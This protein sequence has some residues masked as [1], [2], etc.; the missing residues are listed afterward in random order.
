MSICTGIRVPL[1]Q[2]APDN[3]SGSTRTTSLMHATISAIMDPNVAAG[4]PS[5]AKLWNQ[6]RSGAHPRA[7]A[8][9]NRPGTDRGFIDGRLTS[10]RLFNYWHKLRFDDAL[11]RSHQAQPVDTCGCNDH[12]ISRISQA[13]AERGD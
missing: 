4:A 2:G 10:N 9:G 11:V 7:P 8:L 13:T 3:R 1:K 12:P 6:L 5:N